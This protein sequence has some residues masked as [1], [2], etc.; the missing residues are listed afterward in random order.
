M[1]GLHVFEFQ[2]LSVGR[3]LNVI[4]AGRIIPFTY[5]AILF[6]VQFHLYTT[7]I[8]NLIPINILPLKI[9][10]FK[11]NRTQIVPQIANVGI[12][13]GIHQILWNVSH[14]RL[15]QP[16]CE[17]ALRQL[18]MVSDL[19]LHHFLHDQQRP[20]QESGTVE[21]LNRWLIRVRPHEVKLHALKNLVHLLLCEL[22][23]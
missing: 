13:S 12:M 19:A 8:R 22:V 16:A 9:I 21:L 17:V 2:R 5:C 18:R 3:E 1:N 20:L 11:S 23:I 4:A 10:L 7:R 15:P 6:A 14:R